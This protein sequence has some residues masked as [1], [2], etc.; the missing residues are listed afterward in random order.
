MSG[1]DGI[2][3]VIQ[4]KHD[5]DSDLTAKT[6]AGSVHA[7][8]PASDRR[9]SGEDPERKLEK[10]KSRTHLDTALDPLCITQFPFPSSRACR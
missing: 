6:I 3:W 10:R 9:V 5:P 2:F 1:A 4:S 8:D 7:E